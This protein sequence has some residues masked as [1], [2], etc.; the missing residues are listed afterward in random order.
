MKTMKTLRCAVV[1]TG[2]GMAH[3]VQV[4]AHPRLELAAVCAATPTTLDYLR[5]APVPE[6]LDSVTFT[7][8]RAELIRRA[9]EYPELERTH[10]GTDFDAVLA[11]EDVEAV[12]LA[13]PVYLNAP[14][15]AR[16]LRAGK[17]VL[18]AKPFAVSRE[19]ALDLH[20]TVERSDRAFVLGFEFRRSPLIAAGT[21]D[22]QLRRAGGRAPAV[23]E[24]A[25]HAAAAD[26]RPPGAQ[27]RRVPGR[28]LPLV[29]PLRPLP[30][31][32]PVPARR[33]L[34]RPRPA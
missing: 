27:R 31:R 3:V 20:A 29:R 26:A 30:G 11:L 24:H 9:R 4:L 2:H 25:P 14:F 28:V 7:A 15:A 23:V 19:Q 12:I 1:G 34:R 13:V 18:A 10:L 32:C 21:P 33:R 6:D 16:A 22:R 8:P 5:G 17:H